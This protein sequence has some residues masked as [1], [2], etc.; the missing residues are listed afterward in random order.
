MDVGIGLAAIGML[1]CFACMAMM[2]GMGTGMAR[3]LFRRD[4]RGE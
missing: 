3:R 1:L 4:D 2:I